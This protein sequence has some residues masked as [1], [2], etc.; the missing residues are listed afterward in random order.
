MKNNKNAFRILSI[1]L[2]LVMIIAA[3]PVIGV[4]AEDAAEEPAVEAPEYY[5]WDDVKITFE[6]NSNFFSEGEDGS[7]VASRS[8]L[9]GVD[10]GLKCEDGSM[11]TLSPNTSYRLSFKYKVTAL[12][13]ETNQYIYFFPGRYATERGNQGNYGAIVG[14]A[15]PLDG[16]ITESASFLR[17][18][19]VRITEVMDDYATYTVNFTT[20]SLNRTVNGTEY[21]YDDLLLF[22][23]GMGSIVY[24]DF[25]IAEITE[26]QLAAE[27]YAK[28]TKYFAT[29][30]ST[31]V[32]GGLSTTYATSIYEY[33][34]L[35]GTGKGGTQVRFNNPGSAAILGFYFDG[36]YQLEPSTT[37]TVRFRAYAD[38]IYTKEEKSGSTE[39]I[40]VFPAVGHAPNSSNKINRTGNLY[41]AWSAK[42][43]YSY[44]NDNNVKSKYPFI[45]E[46]KVLKTYECTF[47]TPAT[48][49]TDATDGTCNYFMLA[50]LGKGYDLYIDRIEIAKVTGST[51]YYPN[52]NGAEYTKTPNNTGVTV[53]R[54][55]VMNDAVV[56]P[57][58]LA[59]C[60]TADMSDFKF[61]GWYSD[62]ALEISAVNTDTACYAA[63]DIVNEYTVTR[64][65]TTAPFVY[66]Q[67]LSCD[68]SSGTGSNMSDDNGKLKFENNEASAL[69]RY[70]MIK[71]A[72]YKNF[73]L[74]P[75]SI[76]KIELNYE[77]AD[78]SNIVLG[79][80]TRFDVNLSK[81]PTVLLSVADSPY[82]LDNNANAAGKLVYYFNT[83]DF[84]TYNNWQV[85]QYIDSLAITIRGTGSI[86][87]SDISV[88]A[89]VGENF[90][91]EFT[92][93]GEDMAV[94]LTN[95]PGSATNYALT[96]PADGSEIA[97]HT[98]NRTQV[99]ALGLKVNGAVL[100]DTSDDITGKVYTAALTAGDKVSFDVYKT[101]TAGYGANF[102]VVAAQT[103][104]YP[105]FYNGVRFRIRTNF[106]ESDGV[107]KTYYN[108]KVYTVVDCGVKVGESFVK[109]DVARANSLKTDGTDVSL[110]GAEAYHTTDAYTD[111]TLAVKDV[112]EDKYLYV[113]GYMVLADD[114]DNTVDITVY[115]KNVLVNSFDDLQNSV[116]CAFITIAQR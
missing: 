32:D 65:F 17:N 44:N 51:T 104:D 111:Y 72:D 76:Y 91:S 3:V 22:T 8:T 39:G 85:G 78:D 49:N 64:D 102:A 92:F 101:G 26:E 73:K 70:Y 28:A 103:V 18:E 40:Y 19:A 63:W 86:S 77:L 82:K 99:D 42:T 46:E 56:N 67:D 116:E 61:T 1:I 93:A 68:V 113:A 7:I 54:S 38:E 75:D 95:N 23:Y 87:F 13:D 14:M 20:N 69:E 45:G 84:A 2:S 24:D 10:F 53:N 106:F 98:G 21:L 29:S 6:S 62:P 105:D 57:F 25:E 47:K 31:Y 50:L 60:E 12:T 81:D 90:P 55:I 115:T 110:T 58:E 97:V 15:I 36:E 96:I 37:Y 107:I 71:D 27:D 5:F 66:N 83:S 80:A 16:A 89:L 79:L 94:V 34:V 59:G 109:D 74:Y 43:I 35:T 33:G 11:F 114:N 108:G 30:N 41:A 100:F 88:T 112:D 48:F 9:G 4:I 52:L